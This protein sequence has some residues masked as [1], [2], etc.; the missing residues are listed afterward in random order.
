MPLT[1]YLQGKKMKRTNKKKLPTELKRYTNIDSVIKIIE[2]GRILLTSPKKW[3]DK[4]DLASVEAYM[5]LKGDK[6]IG[7]L[8]LA[9]GLEMV[10]HW[11]TYAKGKKGCCIHF[12]TR[13]FLLKIKKENLLRGWMD[14]KAIK[15][16][17]S[18][19][20][21]KMPLKKIPFIKRRPYEC[22]EEYRIIWTGQ[23]I[24]EQPVIN[25]LDCIK[26][27]T[28]SPD[29][30]PQNETLLKNVMKKRGI[31][32]QIK[33]SKILEEKNWISRFDHL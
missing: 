33:H 16:L 3:K 10:H 19:E 14:Y 30:D 7:V 11:F 4:N 23:N 12:N 17:K 31:N 22:E 2:S 8:C 18:S 21:K 29:C 6:V 25:I 1:K 28:L 32:I 27:I 15:D 26:D 20:L 9:D 13:K 24:E 5:R